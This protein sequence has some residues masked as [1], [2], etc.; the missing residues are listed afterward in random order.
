MSSKA[1]GWV[2]AA[3]FSLFFANVVWGAFN[4]TDPLSNVAETLLLLAASIAFVACVLAEEA[5]T[6][7]RNESG[8]GRR[9]AKGGHRSDDE[10]V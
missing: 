4:R 9:A 3:L 7:A 6:N 10:D 8:A 2:A 1:T 5:R